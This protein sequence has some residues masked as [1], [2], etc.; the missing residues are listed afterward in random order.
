M[1][2][3]YIIEY[4]LDIYETIGISK[5]F[6]IKPLQILFNAAALKSPGSANVLYMVLCFRVFT[7]HYCAFI[8]PSCLTIHDSSSGNPG[9]CLSSA[10]SHPA[11]IIAVA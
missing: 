9:A 6:P 3:K 8:N 5:Q 10:P 7:Q 11:A 4:N 1:L 2:V